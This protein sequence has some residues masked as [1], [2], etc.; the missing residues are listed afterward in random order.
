MKNKCIHLVLFFM[1]AGISL[2]GMD[3]A[4]AAAEQN[5]EPSVS[6]EA[7]A[8]R[9]MRSRKR[10]QSVIRRPMQSRKRRQSVIRRPK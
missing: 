4:V 3:S 5:G 6:Q 1:I 9:P 2:F 8:R 7:K 10:K